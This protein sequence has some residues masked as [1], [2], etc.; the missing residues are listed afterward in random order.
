MQTIR[1]LGLSA[2]LVGVM[3]LGACTSP[4]R[5]DTNDPD[6]NQKS[7][8]VAGGLM[9]ALLGSTKGDNAGERRFNAAVG[10]IL[11]AGAGSLIGQRLDKQEAELRAALG[12]DQVMIV[13]TGDRLIVTMPQDILFATDSTALRPSLRADL[14][15]LARNLQAYPDSRVQVIG[16]TDN[17]GTA[18][19]NEDLSLR[20]AGAVA[21]VLVSEGVDFARISTIGMGEAQ[22]VATNLTTEGRAQN[23]RVEVVIIPN[24]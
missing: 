11:G 21:N 1:K 8:A 17:V 12:N 10:A 18:S 24:G 20:R 2:G 4:A 19:Y 13:N 23:R 14:A 5:F 7:A 15:V 16:H 9:G 3:A 6:Y 22:P